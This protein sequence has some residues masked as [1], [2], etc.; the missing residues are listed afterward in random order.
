MSSPVSAIP[1]IHDPPTTKH[2]QPDQ[3][4]L[5]YQAP[6]NLDT[7]KP[8]ASDD[9][10]SI[11][12]EELNS[13]HAVTIKSCG[14]SF[15]QDCITECLTKTMKCPNCR[16]PAGDPQGPAP[17]GTMNLR[18]LPNQCPGFSFSTTII[19]ITYTI[20][21]GTQ[22][23]YHEHPGQCYFSTTR[24]AYLPDN[25]DGR[26]LA[27]R[28]KYAF[29]HGLTFRIG[30][31]LTTGIPNCVTWA[32]IHHK[33][34]LSGGQHGF[35]DDKYL[36]NCNEALNNLHVPQVVHD[37]DGVDDIGYE[38]PHHLSAQIALPDALERRQSPMLIAGHVPQGRSPSGSMT[39]VRTST[40][41]PGFGVA[42][43]F[44]VTYSIPSN[45][46]M[47]YHPSSGTLH[48]A[49]DR[50]AYIPDTPEGIDLLQRL[51]YAF[52]HGLIFDVGRSLT[53]GLDHQIIWSTVPH[54]TSIECPSSPY[55]FPDPN[56]IE[57]CHSKL[58]AAGVPRSF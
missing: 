37:Y 32:S 46:Q 52:T 58:D 14:H 22:L 42:G 50:I 57:E 5:H 25:S 10:C 20:P 1:L 41:C 21:S 29:D 2:V 33:T 39:I 34:S 35:P 44:E 51:K 3:E 40:I 8:S 16:A 43:T 23:S 54:M 6:A 56:Y 38:A 18:K 17:S 7:T 19:E 55:S 9:E 27:N 48:N 31:S 36:D 24:I 12:L 28:L 4:I 53:N 15:H 30:T 11:C 13:E 26:A 45:I 49:T 47:P